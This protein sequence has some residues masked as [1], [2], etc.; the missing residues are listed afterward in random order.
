MVGEAI[1]KKPEQTNE[2]K[3]KTAWDD[4]TKLAQSETW[5]EHLSKADGLASDYTGGRGRDPK[6]QDEREFVQKM[7][8]YRRGKLEGDIHTIGKTEK[9]QNQRSQEFFE[10][11]I[12]SRLT[13]IE[14]LDIYSGVEGSGVEKTSIKYDNQEIPIYNLSD[15]PI[16]FIQT[17]LDYKKDLSE[18]DK[19]LNQKTISKMEEVLDDP[20]IWNTHETDINLT[21]DDLQN[22]RQGKSNRISVSYINCGDAESLR[23]RFD[24]DCCYGFSHLDGNSVIDA[25]MTDIVSRS[26]IGKDDSKLTEDKVQ[27][28]LT[29]LEHPGESHYKGFNGA[30]NEIVIRRYNENGE[31]KRPD[32]MVVQD[33]NINPVALKHAKYFNIPIVNINTKTYLYSD[34]TISK[35]YTTE[36][37]SENYADLLAAGANPNFIKSKL[38]AETAWD[39]YDT[40]KTYMPDLDVNTEFDNL[41]NSRY[42]QEITKLGD[43]PSVDSQR[44]TYSDVVYNA[45]MSDVYDFLDRGGDKSQ[46]LKM[47][48][49]TGDAEVVKYTQ[50]LLA[51][52]E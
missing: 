33:G 41:I 31:P 9:F 46:L 51:T 47:A 40:L 48:N 24:G 14:E 29:D 5:E 11:E 18:D 15:Y 49:R 13:D 28:L 2:L 52:T 1:A 42:S 23:R 22:G 10:R 50:Q 44:Q 26:D 32:F 35:E 21:D 20:S 43:N 4:L 3:E 37:I 12:N 45:M 19:R 8:E 34:E 39:N 25:D 30:Y 16:H 27:R 38:S 17:V 36:Q 7:D 6:F